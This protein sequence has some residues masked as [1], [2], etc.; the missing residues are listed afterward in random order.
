MSEAGIGP[1]LTRRTAGIPRI[2]AVQWFSGQSAHTDSI[3]VAVVGGG[4]GEGQAQ[5][6]FEGALYAEA[7]TGGEQDA[8]VR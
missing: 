1:A 2:P 5:E 3:G 7:R 6:P 8:V 4:V